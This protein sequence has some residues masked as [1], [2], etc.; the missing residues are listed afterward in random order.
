MEEQTGERWH[1]L[2]VQAMEEHDPKRLMG[3]IAEL[4]ALLT[5]EEQ[6]IQEELEQSR[7]PRAGRVIA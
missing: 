6:A 3:L 7:R 1:K 5:S 2:C 4:H